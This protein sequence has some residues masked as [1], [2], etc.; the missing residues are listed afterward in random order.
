M[1]LLTL[2]NILK[3]YENRTLL[4]NVSLRVER[5]ERLALT[6]P[7]GSGKTTLIRIAMGLEKFDGGKVVIAK[8]TKTGYLTQG[9]LEF[10]N[11]VTEAG[12]TA[13][14][15]EKISRME[16]KLRGLEKQME[17]ISGE[18]QPEA[19][20]RLLEEYSKLLNRYE[21]MNGYTIELKIKTILL[22][23][24]LKEEALSVSVSKLSGGEK[25][26]VAM[27]RL[28]IEEPDLLIL[29]EPTNH[30][31]IQ[32]T[33]WLEGFLRKFAGGVLFVSHDRYFLDQVATRVAELD[34]GGITERSGSY[35]VFIEQKNR[36]RE[37]A[38]K[39]QKRLEM[40]IRVAE[41]KALSLKGQSNHRTRNISAWKSRM[42]MVERLK[43]DLNKNTE[44]FKRR[45]HLNKTFAPRIVF[46]NVKHV[47]SEIA[48]AEGLKKS[49]GDLVLF[50]GVDFLIR[51]GERVGIIGSNGCGKTTLLNILL[52]S[53]KDFEG[54]ARLGHWVRYAYLGQDI[55]F[56]DEN[57]TILEE[58][59]SWRE[60]P[61]PQARDYLSGFQFYG[62]DVY[63]CID[64]LSGG[65]RVRLYLACIM[66]MEPDC[67]IMDEPTNHLDVV[68]R[69]AVEKALTG[70]KGTVIAVSHDRYFL[71]KCIN[72]IM[73]INEGKMYIY[74]GNYEFYRQ[75]KTGNVPYINADGKSSID[76]SRIG[77]VSKSLPGSVTGAKTPEKPDRENIEIDIIRLEDKLKELENSFGKE[78]PADVYREYESIANELKGLYAMWE[79]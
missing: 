59:I 79:M 11:A 14:H 12:E 18:M 53:D 55:D 63:K 13:V 51:G 74:Q 75:V 78:T 6:G 58:T 47:S 32:A 21:G 62:G 26:R 10:C 66:L 16:R 28:L 31:D 15:Y 67:L 69:D 37:F 48:K 42:K 64:I 49:F 5:G 38:V 25:M 20:K 24:G 56:I 76:K 1:S 46:K 43:E 23:L 73:E 35:S 2:E 29:D 27:A 54:Y 19:Y 36:M 72:R 3:E 44:D 71:T 33:E 57:R 30:L 65:E 41:E 40:Q 68:A 45:E 52:G 60:M 70:F 17:S 39:E 8:G 77:A 4:D 34:N 61:E 22:G 9:L 50:S 7:N